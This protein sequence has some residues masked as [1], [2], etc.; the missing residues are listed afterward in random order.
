[1]GEGSYS[2]TWVWSL[3]ESKLFLLMKT[4]TFLHYKTTTTTIKASFVKTTLPSACVHLTLFKPHRATL[5]TM[6]VQPPSHHGV[7][8]L[9]QPLPVPLFFHAQV[10]TPLLSFG[11]FFHVTMKLFNYVKSTHGPWAVFIALRFP[12]GIFHHWVDY[13]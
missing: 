3:L 12:H 8:A 11:R 2:F 4:F 10:P 13:T 1:M 7:L 5:V 9:A 6:S